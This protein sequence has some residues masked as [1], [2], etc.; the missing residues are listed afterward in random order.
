MPGLE[1]PL[2][3][4]ARNKAFIDQKLLTYVY[5]RD[6]SAFYRR[7]DQGPK[8]EIPLLMVPVLLQLR[9]LEFGRSLRVLAITIYGNKSCFESGH[10]LLFDVNIEAHSRS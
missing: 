2:V 9:R 5:P 6:F 4:L 1:P 3:A 7:G 8:P 10:L